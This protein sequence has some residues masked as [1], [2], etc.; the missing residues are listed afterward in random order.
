MQ[1]NKNLGKIIR[2]GDSLGMIER[3]YPDG[4]Y[5]VYL[6]CPQ[7]GK[8]RAKVKTGDIEILNDRQRFQ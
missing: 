6:F 1:H 4:D 5:S 3:Q 7:S 2:Y 8:R